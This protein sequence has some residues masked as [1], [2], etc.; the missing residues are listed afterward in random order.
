MKWILLLRALAVETAP[1]WPSATKPAFAGRDEAY[2]YIVLQFIL[3]AFPARHV[4]GPAGSWRY[5][6]GTGQ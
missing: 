1:S 3:P 2:P 6:Y 4:D 5:K